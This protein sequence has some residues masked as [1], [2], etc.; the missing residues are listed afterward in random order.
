MLKPCTIPSDGGGFS[1]K[2]AVFC[3][4]MLEIFDDIMI[5]SSREDFFQPNLQQLNTF[6]LVVITSQVQDY[7]GL[8]VVLIFE[9]CKKI[10]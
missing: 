3:F 10:R 7:S 4:T 8:W 5:L 6:I 1:L 9:T 2:K